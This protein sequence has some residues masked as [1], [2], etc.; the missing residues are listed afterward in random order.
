MIDSKNVIII[1]GPTASGKSD[2]AIQVAK[3]L[4]G[5][6]ISADSSQVYVGLDIGSAKIKKED[7]QSIKHY[8]LDIKDPTQDF[9]VAEFKELALKNVKD[10]LNKNKTPIICGGTGLYVRA[11][12]DDYDFDFTPKSEELRAKIEKQIEENGIDCAYQTLKSLSIS[13]ASKINPN[14]KV[15]IIRALEKELCEKQ[16]TKQL[17]NDFNY[18]VY[19]IDIDRNLLYQRINDRVDK[20]VELGLFDEVKKLM[21]QGITTK[22]SCFKSIGYKEVYDYFTTKELDKQQTIELIKKKT[23][24]YAKRQLTFF[25]GIKQAVWLRSDDKLSEL[26]QDYNKKSKE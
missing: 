18:F 12:I 14:D 17:E 8:M 9:C 7:M 19:V 3:K 4:D 13:K 1:I 25:R 15:R 10:I 22:N 26:L 6:V 24:N 21:E 11:L 5:E 23:R 2:L 20:M 16:T